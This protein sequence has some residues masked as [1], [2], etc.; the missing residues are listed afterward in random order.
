LSTC[1]VLSSV[2][3]D[4]DGDF[5]VVTAEELLCS[6]DNVSDHDGGAQREDEVLVVGVQDKSIVHLACKK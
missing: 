3:D 4:D 2:R 6:A 1:N 5:V